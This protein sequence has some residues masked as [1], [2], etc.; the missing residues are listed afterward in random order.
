MKG[1][2]AAP[3]AWGLLLLLLGAILGVAF[4][5]PVPA[6]LFVIGAAPV[7]AVAAWNQARPA[8]A[9]PR[10]LPRLS[11]PVVVL[12]VGLAVAAVGLTAGA[13]LGIVGG[14]IALFG[15]VWLGRELVDER[16]SR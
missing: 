8:R 9:E 15:A 14:E 2:A 16:R 7:L 12:A 4:S 6:L 3:L 11:V 1:S 5:E 13:W 10:L